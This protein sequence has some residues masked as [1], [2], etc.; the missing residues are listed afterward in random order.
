VGFAAAAANVLGA[1]LVS[2][3]VDTG[4]PDGAAG[5]VAAGG[6]AIGVTMRLTVGW[7]A[8]RGTRE[9]LAIVMT[10]LA[11]G[12]VGFLMLS[13]EFVPIF[14]L[15]VVFAFGAGWAWPGL[16]NYAVSQRYGGAAA[17]ATGVTQSG[18]YVGGALGPL[19]FGVLV[20][21]TSYS[22][23]WLAV[24][25]IVA[26]GVAC[27]WAGRAMIARRSIEPEPLIVT[28]G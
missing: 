22:V 24:A 15:G 23:G 6:S 2:S 1:F 20:E 13:T 16:F 17:A 3:A 9:P 21:A 27:L 18:V 7:L 11:G 10:M 4:L 25:V 12:I 5:L 28:G 26:L 8:D 14:L 19:A